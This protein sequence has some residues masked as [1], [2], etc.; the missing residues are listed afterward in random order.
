MLDSSISRPECF[1]ETR[2]NG[3]NE[4]DREIRESGGTNRDKQRDKCLRM[5]EH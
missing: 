2:L 3:R 5:R 1:L 4:S